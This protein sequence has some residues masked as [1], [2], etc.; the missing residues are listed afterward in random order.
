[1]YLLTEHSTG[2]KQ[3]RNHNEK[4]RTRHSKLAYYERIS[5]LHVY[6]DT[7]ASKEPKRQTQLEMKKIEEL[8]TCKKQKEKMRSSQVCNWSALIISTP[9]NPMKPGIFTAT[10]FSQTKSFSHT[11]STKRVTNASIVLFCLLIWR[12]K[13]HPLRGT[14]GDP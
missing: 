2:N 12:W 13:V 10:V 14:T 3:P 1:M 4:S 8:Q 5:P 6:S 9:P 11:P 7:Q